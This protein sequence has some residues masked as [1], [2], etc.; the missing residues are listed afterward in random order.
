MENNNNDRPI[1]VIMFLNVFKIKGQ[2]KMSLSEQLKWKRWKIPSIDRMW[3]NQNAEN[4]I[5]IDAR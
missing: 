1:V 4:V 5:M 2:I 3:S